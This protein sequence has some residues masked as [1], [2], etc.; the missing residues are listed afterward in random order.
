MNFPRFQIAAESKQFFHMMDAPDAMAEFK[1]EGCGDLYVFFL[2]VKDN[3]LTEIAYFTPGCGFGR[4]TCHLLSELVVGKT[5][6]EAEKVTPADIE[7]ALEG[8]PP[9]KN[10]YPGAVHH[11]LQLAIANYRSGQKPDP[12]SVTDKIMSAWS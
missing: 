11:T 8:Y 3:V 6:E 2:K 10:H 12:A 4:A 9:K 7:K 5:L 1:N